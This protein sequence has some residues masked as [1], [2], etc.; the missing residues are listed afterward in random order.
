MTP[1][2]RPPAFLLTRPMAQSRCFAEQLRAGLGAL[3]VVISPLMAPEF[4]PF[5]LPDHDLAAVIF[6]S[7]T[8]VDAVVR[9]GTAPRLPRLA[10]CVGDRTAAVAR[11]AGFNARSADGDAEALIA[12]IRADPPPGPLL[13]LRGEEARGD[14][15]P[16]LTAA[17]IATASCVLYRQVPQ[18]LNQQ[19][20]ALLAQPRLVVLPLFSP[21]TARLC[22]EALAGI[23]L[24]AHLV[25]AALSPA[26]D[27]AAAGL[28][29]RQRLTAPQPNAKSLVETLVAARSSEVWLETPRP[30]N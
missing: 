11:D 14:I 25:T 12:A 29:A 26:V 17:G 2:S 5:E 27:A 6:T 3:D 30:S 1:Q 19:A 23:D 18:R 24:A 9:A 7:A 10:W 15:A 16:R 21:R 28:S 8:A 13:H 22:A 4:L 20:L